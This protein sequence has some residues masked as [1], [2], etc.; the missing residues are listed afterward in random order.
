MTIGEVEEFLWSLSTT[1]EG[2][3]GNWQIRFSNATVSVRVDPEAD[4]LAISAPITFLPTPALQGYVSPA[5]VGYQRDETDV[6]AVF[7][8]HLSSLAMNGLQAGFQ[9]V[10]DCARKTPDKL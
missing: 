6:R 9:Q 4:L 10:V 8:T 2:E 1:L 3:I 5:G 7:A